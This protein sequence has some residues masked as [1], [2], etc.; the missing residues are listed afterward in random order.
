M[1]NDSFQP[2]VSPDAVKSTAKSSRLVVLTQ[3]T[4][5]RRF[6]PNADNSSISAAL[7]ASGTKSESPNG[8]ITVQR[9]GEAIKVIEVRCNCGEVH[10]IECGY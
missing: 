5:V 6:T 3:P 10:Q 1:K 9:E 7:D 8:R 4:A 2:L